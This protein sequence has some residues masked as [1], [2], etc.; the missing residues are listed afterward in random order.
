MAK[1]CCLFVFF[2]YPCFHAL[3]LLTC[4]LSLIGI[5]T[6]NSGCQ[7]KTFLLTREET[8]FSKIIVF[9]FFPSLSVNGI[10]SSSHTHRHTRTHS[11]PSM[12]VF[13]GFSFSHVQLHC[14]CFFFSSLLLLRVRRDCSLDCVSDVV[15]R[16]T[17]LSNEIMA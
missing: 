9:F 8:I 10:L 3:F 15:G 17:S 13:N 7:V 16:V 12:D 4:A 5:S 14:V 6:N 11:L 1:N 2:S